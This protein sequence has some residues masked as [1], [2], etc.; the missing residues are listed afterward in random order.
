MSKYAEMIDS[1]IDL[2]KIHIFDFFTYYFDNPEMGRIKDVDGYALFGCKIKSMLKKDQKYVFV[3]IRLNKVQGISSARLKDLEWD[4]L[5]TRTLEEIYSVPL[6]SYSVKQDE[7]VN[8]AISI[9]KK[10]DRQYLYTN[11]VYKII[12]TL[13]FSKNQT[14]PFGDRG[15]LGMALE[16]FNCI[17]SFS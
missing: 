9:L 7:S 6:H 4:V 5:Q 8:S 17:I 11:A 10:E 15:T 16:S 3:L 12:V 13:I 14:R 2:N 1:G